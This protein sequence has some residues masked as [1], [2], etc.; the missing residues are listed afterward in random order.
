MLIAESIWELSLTRSSNRAIDNSGLVSWLC[1]SLWGSRCEAPRAAVA[2][3]TKRRVRGGCQCGCSDPR[4]AASSGAP[5]AGSVA[6]NPTAVPPPAAR[7]A[8]T[9][10]QAPP[11]TV[12]ARRRPPSA[13]GAP[14][15]LTAACRRSGPADSGVLPRALP[16]P[17]LRL[18]LL[19]H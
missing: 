6:S 7:C 12:T 18:L 13:S 4:A 8:A 9:P 15:A 1:C 14:P 2:R 17:L 10:P 19:P 3:C 11:L 5:A 16:A